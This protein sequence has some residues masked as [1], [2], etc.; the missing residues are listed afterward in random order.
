MTETREAIKLDSNKNAMAI[1]DSQLLISQAQN[2]NEIIEIKKPKYKQF[3]RGLFFTDVVYPQGKESIKLALFA[4][5]S[6]GNRPNL[7]ELPFNTVYGFNDSLQLRL[8]WSSFVARDV[9]NRVADN[10]KIITKVVHEFDVLKKS[11]R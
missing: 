4:I 3:V 5:F 7:F 2:Q 8:L 11:N 10:F 6:D 9:E 1:K